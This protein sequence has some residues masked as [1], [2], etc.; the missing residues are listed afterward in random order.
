MRPLRTLLAL[1]LAAA[2]HSSAHAQSTNNAAQ[3]R[4]IS[5]EEAVQLALQN[6]L[7]L[8]IERFNPQLSLL[9]LSGSEAYW[10]PTF[11]LN[12]RQSYRSNPGQFNPTFGFQ[13]APTVSVTESFGSGFSGIAPWGLRYDA[14]ID[15]TRNSTSRPGPNGDP[16]SNPYEY[17]SGADITLRQPLLRDF[18]IDQNRYAIQIGK[19]AVE[20]SEFA[21]QRR[22][23]EIVTAVETAYYNL[24][25]AHE[26]VR[27]QQLA[28]QL[29]QRSLEEN[30]KRVQV[31][32]MAL[33]EEKQ[34]ESLVASGRADLLQANQQLS[35]AQNQLKDLLTGNYED[36]AIVQFEP[37]E[38]LLPTVVPFDLQESWRRAMT[39]RPDLQE[40]RVNIERQDI[41]LK[42]QKNQLFPALDIV[43]SYGHSARNSNTRGVLDDIRRGH[44]PVWYYG[45]ELSIPLGN[46]AR[47]N[48]YKATKAEK[49][50]L[51]LRLKRLEQNILLEVDN[52]VKLAQLQL[53]KIEA[54]RQ[55]RL[56]AEAAL[57]AEQKKLESGKST[58]FVVLTLQRDLTRARSEEV[59]ALADYNTAL[60][61]LALR[62]GSTLERNKLYFK[63]D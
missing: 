33:L 36:L 42:Y 13:V 9:D 35:V 27:V 60:A 11:N 55:A 8:Q 51:L 14:G 44:D 39:S 61:Q 56:Y 63:K 34:A 45:A 53:E 41:T 28:L 1:G 29:S 26:F 47:R 3:V 38:K 16:I 62:E 22:V 43:G 32:T 24:I 58:S 31:G 6:N 7:D 21:L 57:D 10:E 54:T 25:A 15:L 50:Q 4:A 19:K 5:L 23:Q 20:M 17:G 30:R 46:T 49:E 2:L 37:T 48:A 40:A 59:R 12:G 18:W 52:A